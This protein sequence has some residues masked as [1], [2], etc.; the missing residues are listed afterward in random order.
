M[1]RVDGI[2]PA[3]FNE[4]QLVGELEDRETEYNGLV[5][6]LATRVNSGST[7]EGKLYRNTAVADPKKVVD[8]KADLPMN[9]MSGYALKFLKCRYAGSFCLTPSEREFGHGREQ[10]ISESIWMGKGREMDQNFMQVLCDPVVFCPTKES[11]GKE[12]VRN[13]FAFINPDNE[14]L[15]PEK[16]RRARDFLRG[17]NGGRVQ[18]TLLSGFEALDNL[19]NFDEFKNFDCTYGKGSA[20]WGDVS[21]YPEFQG[22][23]FRQVENHVEYA[24]NGTDDI[25]QTPVIPI[26]PNY[27]ADGNI[28][29][30]YEVHWVPL[31]DRATVGYEPWHELCISMQDN[32]PNKLK[33]LLNIDFEYGY[34]LTRMRTKNVVWIGA[35]VRKNECVEWKS[36]P[37]NR[38]FPT[39]TDGV[40]AA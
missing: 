1:A 19:S 23:T 32:L 39:V 35:L 9:K 38:K 27:D 33:K 18:P 11:G 37:Y 8:E 7:L 29:P 21:R 34:G 36:N 4:A 26:T 10:T 24:M 13:D 12:I 14:G 5:E 22:L 15:T 28:D 31:Y 6:A 25:L 16:L 30:D 40:V 3:D 2:L 17:G 20:L